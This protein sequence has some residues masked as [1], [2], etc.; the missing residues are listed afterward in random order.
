MK[1]D[2]RTMQFFEH[3]ESASRPTTRIRDEIDDRFKWRVED[4][5]EDWSAWEKDLQSV[6]GLMDE[7]VAYKGRL[8]EGPEVLVKTHQLSDQIGMTAYKL[9]RFPQLQFDVDQRNNA[10]QSR[11]QQVQNLFAEYGT[12]TAWFTPELLSLGSEKVMAWVASTPELKAYEF[13][14]AETFRAQEHVLDEAGEQLLSFGS[15][16]RSTPG[17]VYRALSTADVK[18]NTITLANGEETT[19]SPGTYRNLLETNRNQDDRRKAFEAMYSIFDDK[20][21]TFA[22]IYNAICQRDWMSAQSRNYSGTAEAALDSDNVPVSV[23]ET[24]IE[25]AREGAEPLRRYHKL[26]KKF[27][28]L[29]K[30][31]LYDSFVPLVEK[32][33]EYPYDNVSEMI[34]EAM[35]PLGSE[36]QEKLAESLEGGWIDVYENDGK[37]SGAYSAGVYGV[38]PYMLLN[39]TDTLNDVFTLVH[40]LGHTLHTVYSHEH[41]PFATSSYT[42]FVAEVAST[43]NE[44]LLLDYLK[45][46]RHEPLDRAIL[47]QHAISEIVGTFYSQ[48]LFAD[49]ELKAHRLVESGAPIT[50][51]VLSNLYDEVQNSFYGDAVDQDPLYKLTWARIPHFF[52]SPFYVYQYATCFASSAQI[53]KG[54]LNEDSDVRE[55]TRTKYLELLSSGGN[56]HPME[57]LKKAGVDL[58]D[59]GTVRAVVDQLNTLVDELEAAL[60]AL[61]A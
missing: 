61:N 39:Y 5:Y 35:A 6:R 49:Y 12:R 50:A 57:Q 16:F 24:L 52:N 4:I 1:T 27:L 30:Y 59:A 44:A 60:E 38:H 58:N 46:R 43:T 29:D 26:R 18:Y 45:A 19:V 54:L 9:Y 2:G 33:E 36:Y 3:K 25:T 56:N 23:L 22:S 47:L 51:E 31:Y 21:N 14:I 48:A 15:R 53:I 37:R 20:K 34:V 7:F 8:N 13:P 28:K 11:L 42:I 17:D 55:A 40:E 32:D 41:Q 10:I